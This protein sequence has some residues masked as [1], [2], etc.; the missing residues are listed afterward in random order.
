MV[1]DRHKLE[2]AEVPVQL[3]FQAGGRT[4][5]GN[6][7]R[8]RQSATSKSDFASCQSGRGLRKQD[9]ESAPLKKP[10]LV[11]G[12]F[13]KF[14]YKTLTIRFPKYKKNGIQTIIHSI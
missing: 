9:T 14:M 2:L 7:P 1:C 5:V 12:F 6:K 3:S 10:L 8:K 4:P 11:R 13:M